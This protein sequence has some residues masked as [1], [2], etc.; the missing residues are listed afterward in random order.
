MRWTCA[1]GPTKASLAWA[2]EVQALAA[3]WSLEVEM[4]SADC[5]AWL[6]FEPETTSAFGLVRWE[7]HRE[8]SAGYGWA[9]WTCAGWAA[10]TPE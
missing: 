10:R 9:V 5:S 1:A 2:G 7:R 8:D 6:V 4:R 3:D